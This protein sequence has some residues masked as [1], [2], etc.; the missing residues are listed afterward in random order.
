M[1]AK[2]RDSFGL[3][4]L[5]D[6]IDNKNGTYTGTYKPTVKGTHSLSVYIRE[7][8]IFESPFE[9]NVTAGIEID[10][11][12]P[13]LLKFGSHG[14]LGQS[15]GNEESFEPWGI[16]SNE[17]GSIFVSDHNNHQILVRKNVLYKY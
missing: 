2:I 16:A 8:P 1:T 4:N 7:K 13:M 3:I 17:A 5:A 12:G 10:K 6:I 14:V 9:L 15:K 11:T